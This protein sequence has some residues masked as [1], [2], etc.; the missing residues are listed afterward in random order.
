M[1]TFPENV[2]AT[3][4]CLLS[5]VTINRNVFDVLFLNSGGVQWKLW[6]LWNPMLTC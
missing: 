4:I 3:L 2:I 5:S 1:K 6:T